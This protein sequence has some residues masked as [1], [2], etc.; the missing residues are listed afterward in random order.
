MYNNVLNYLSH[1]LSPLEKVCAV[2]KCRT[3]YQEMSIC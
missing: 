2:A 1:I 3:T